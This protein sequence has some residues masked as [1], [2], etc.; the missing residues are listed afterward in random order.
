VNLNWTATAIATLDSISRY[1][2]EE[3]DERTARVMEGRIITKVGEIP[4]FPK[5]GRAVPELNTPE[6][7]EVFVGSYRIVYQL[8]SVESPTRIDV[9]GVVHGSQLFENTAV[10]S[11]V[12]DD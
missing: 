12:D 6:I 3:A 9:L 10:W 1:L 5:S 8:D 11:L 4:S 2:A 7:R